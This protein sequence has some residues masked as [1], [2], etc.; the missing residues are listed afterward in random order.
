[1]PG[2]KEAPAGRNSS[3]FSLVE[4]TVTLGLASILGLGVMTLKNALDKTAAS[5]NLT[6]QADAFRKEVINLLKDR[7]SWRHTLQNNSTFSCVTDTTNCYGAIANGPPAASTPSNDPDYYNYVIGSGVGA[8]VGLAC[9]GGFDVY[10][11]NANA[12]VNFYPSVTTPAKGFTQNGAL[13]DSYPNAPCS[14]RLVLWW[15]PICPNIGNPC[16]APMV[17]VRGYTLFT[18][19]G[20]PMNI[21]F[22]PANYSIDMILPPIYQ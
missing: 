22:N 4:L 21:P 11:K 8:C 9:K 15:N 17:R 16:Y 19:T 7:D 5:S 12:T 10:R 13:C 20:E 6:T 2:S 1:M 3:G 14:F 18:P